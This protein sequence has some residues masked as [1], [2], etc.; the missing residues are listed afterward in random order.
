MFVGCAYTHCLPF[1]TSEFLGNWFRRIFFEILKAALHREDSLVWKVQ[2]MW[3]KA[4]TWTFV[5]V[6]PAGANDQYN[7][8]KNVWK[9]YSR[10]PPEHEEHLKNCE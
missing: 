1:W 2:K 9:L 10:A 7:S 3:L 5:Q 8:Q 6:M 4:P